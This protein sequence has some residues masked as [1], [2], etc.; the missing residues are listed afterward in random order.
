MYQKYIRSP[1]LN[2]SS[3]S[4]P[5]ETQYKLINPR[6]MDSLLS[7]PSPPLQ[8]WVKLKMKNRLGRT[9]LTPWEH[10]INPLG[11]N[12][13]QVEKRGSRSSGLVEYDRTYSRSYCG[14]VEKILFSEFRQT[15]GKCRLMKPT[16][17]VFSMSA[18]IRTEISF[19]S[20]QIVE[21]WMSIDRFAF[22]VFLLNGTFF[23]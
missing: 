10:S 7:T 19:I 14:S 22:F 3:W 16:N 8:G 2:L 21:K 12:P 20:R 4:T 13:P 9:S 6:E 15:S 1:F 11:V 23:L 18:W 5:S 17:P